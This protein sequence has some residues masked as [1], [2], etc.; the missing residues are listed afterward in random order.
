[1]LAK[2]AGL[3][4]DM[5][6][7]IEASTIEVQ[8]G[9]NIIKFELRSVFATIPALT[10]TME[11]YEQGVYRVQIQEIASLHQRY[12]VPDEDSFM[13]ENLKPVVLDDRNV[14]LSKE[15]ITFTDKNYKV[16]IFYIPFQIL[17][18]V[19]NNE[20]ISI[21][22]R[23]LMNFEM[24]RKE[25]QSMLVNTELELKIEEPVEIYD[26]TAIMIHDEKEKIFKS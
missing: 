10:G 5:D 9:T 26:A 1:M 16:E 20:V 24:Y 25:G 4:Y 19:D 14:Q 8:K 2:P 3:K 22:D 18:Y 12:Q 7:T 15:K 17:G 13:T 21:N 6:Y 23:S 11:F